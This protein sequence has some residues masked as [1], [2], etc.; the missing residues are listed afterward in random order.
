[1][2]N[3]IHSH[4]H[5]LLKLAEWLGLIAA[6]MAVLM[7]IWLLL[8]IN[9][10]DTFNLLVFQAMQAICIFI[11]PTWL[12]ACLWSEQPETFL[13]LKPLVQTDKTLLLLSIA[14]IICALPLINCLAYW[15]S[16]I[17]LPDCLQGLEAKMQKWE[18]DA[19][20]LLKAFMS[21]ENGSLIFLLINIL[22]LA[23][24]PAIGEEM[25]FRGVLQ[26]F[27]RRNKHL[28]VW[29]TAIIFS[30]I[31]FQFYGFIPRMLLGALLG[32]ALIWT[33]NLIYS[34]TMHAT[35]NTIAVLLF[36]I[37]TFVL[38]MPEKEM[39][40]LGTGDTWWLTALSVPLTA[41]CIYLFRRRALSLHKHTA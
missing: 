33:D 11:V 3:G 32:Y 6:A 30:F 8:P 2:T 15:N 16:Q 38:H 36:Y 5:P 17:V 18:E 22:V 19:A 35:N 31:H 40:Y 25:T 9:H 23:F 10:L 20:R 27:F 1:M 14:T 39:D 7:T 12:V 26:S 34:I 4:L 29:L 37:A 41:V 28:A 21:I 24:L 13:H